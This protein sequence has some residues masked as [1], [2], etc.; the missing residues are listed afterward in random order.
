MLA[1][2]RTTFDSFLF[3]DLDSHLLMDVHHLFDY[4]DSKNVD[5]LFWSD[6]AP[7]WLNNPILSEYP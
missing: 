6:I 2:L 7:I 3:L 4:L 5:A 1:M